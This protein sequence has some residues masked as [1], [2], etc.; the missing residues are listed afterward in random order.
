MRMRKY[1]VGIVISLLTMVFIQS[2]HARMSEADLDA[3]GP[4][5]MQSIDDVDRGN[6][7]D[8]GRLWVSV[9]PSSATNSHR[10]ARVAE[11]SCLEL[12]DRHGRTALHHATIRGSYRLVR[13]LLAAGADVDSRDNQGQTALNL[14]VSRGLWEIAD[15]LVDAGAD[16]EAVGG[17]TGRVPHTRATERYMTA[18][19]AQVVPGATS[20]G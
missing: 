4:H 5:S 9:L 16:A 13:L 14:A 1:S 3:A 6:C 17:S 2:S 15:A 10:P 8:K 7:C 11:G 18:L 20:K 19:R 12:R